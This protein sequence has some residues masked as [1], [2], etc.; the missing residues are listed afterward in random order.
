VSLVYWD[1]TL[2][3]YWLEDKQPYSQLI[4]AIH[5]RM[6]QRG[7]R[8]CTGAFTLGELLVAPEKQNDQIL[9]DKIQT[10]FDGPS[11]E[12]LPFDT[13]TARQYAKIRSS[14][15]VSPADA[16]HLATASSA[17]VDLFL[18]NDREVQ[19][20]IVPGIQF[21]DGLTTTALGPVE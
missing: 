15:K 14:G 9:R 8:L 20:L 6:A 12:V 4:D 7:D 5:R 1:T 21:I 11:V 13:V 17:S 10:Y 18:T 16:I 2:F 3:V 19:K